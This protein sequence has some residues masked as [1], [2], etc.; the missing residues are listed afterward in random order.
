MVTTND[1]VT[2]VIVAAGRGA[3]L[4]SDMPKAL[5]NLGDRP[6]LQYSLACFDAHGAVDHMVVVVHESM[7]ARVRE[8]VL[9]ARIGTPLDIVAGG[10][11][12]WQ[13]VRNGVAA[14]SPHAEWL[15]V[16]D[17][18]RPFVTAA[19]I[20]A[21]LEKREAYR[22]AITATPVADT[23]RRFEGDRCVATLDRG[24]LVRVGTPQMFHRPSLLEALSHA[25]DVDSPPTDE[26]VLM[27]RCGIPVGLAWGDPLNFKITTKE[28]LLLA[29]GLIQQRNRH[30]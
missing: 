29:E 7:I 16:H 9:R 13:S 23:V 12:R 5:V 11:H 1:S 3:R 26:A 25:S 21:L 8:M 24:K 14:T 15:L 2:A 19:V 28:D 20:D 6:M 17:A 18:A 4:G 27:E 10:E 30:R 22:C